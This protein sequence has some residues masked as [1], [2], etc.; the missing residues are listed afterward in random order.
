MRRLDSRIGS[1]TERPARPNANM[2]YGGDGFCDVALAHAECAFAL[3]ARHAKD[4]ALSRGG[5]S[6]GIS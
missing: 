1:S 5:L 3:D 6:H 4:S 2:P